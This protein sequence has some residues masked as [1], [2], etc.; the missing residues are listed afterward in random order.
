MRA[1]FRRVA[2][3]DWQRSEEI[4]DLTAPAADDDGLVARWLRLSLANSVPDPAYLLRQRP[5]ETAV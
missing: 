4:L 1:V 2:S 5:E 3:K